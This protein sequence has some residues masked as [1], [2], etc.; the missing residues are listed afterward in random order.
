MRG[1]NDLGGN[2]EL[3]KARAQSFRET[4][5]ASNLAPSGDQYS[6][7]IPIFHWLLHTEQNGR[8][9]RFKTNVNLSKK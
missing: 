2:S 3:A 6:R 5:D 8:C 9:K 1:R 7:W 4:R